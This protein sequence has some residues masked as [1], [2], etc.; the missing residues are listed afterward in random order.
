MPDMDGLA[1]QQALSDRGV[2][3]P[4]IFLTGQGDI[5]MTVRAMKGGAIDFL[6]KPASDVQILERVHAAMAHDGKTPARSTAESG[7]G[8]SASSA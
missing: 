5:P 2:S 1:L 4:I 8:K 7:T 6:E 3:L